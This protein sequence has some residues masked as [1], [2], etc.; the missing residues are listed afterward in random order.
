[1]IRTKFKNIL[2]SCGKNGACKE[3]QIALQKSANP[4]MINVDH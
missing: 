1:M 2:T 4:I 3:T